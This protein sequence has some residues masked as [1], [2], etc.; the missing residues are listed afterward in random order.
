[1]LNGSRAFGSKRKQLAGVFAE[2]C[3]TSQG[4][5]SCCCGAVTM[6]QAPTKLIAAGS[7]TYVNSV[8]YAPHGPMQQ[9]GLASGRYELDCFNLRLQPTG[10]LLRTQAPSASLCADA[11]SNL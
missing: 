5:P 8:S 10:M 2:A 1:M 9:I 3:Q 7:T 4:I 6:R 11:A